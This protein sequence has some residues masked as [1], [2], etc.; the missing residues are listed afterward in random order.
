MKYCRNC[1][2]E[3]SD[4]AII[5]PKCGCSVDYENKMNFNNQVPTNTESYSVM[6]ILGMVFAFVE[7][8]VGLILS[9][10]AYNDAKKTGNTKSLS[11]EK[12]GIITSSVFLGL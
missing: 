5:C 10:V 4:A 12:A 7:S 6:S 8:L 11:L 9:I 3:V 1:G 2:N